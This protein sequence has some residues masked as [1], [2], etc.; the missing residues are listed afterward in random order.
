MVPMPN[1][2]SNNIR[3]HARVVI[4]A[5]ALL[6]AGLAIHPTAHLHAQSSPPAGSSQ[7]VTFGIVG[8]AQGQWARLNALLLPVGGPMRAGACEVTF[9][10]L[11]DQGATLSSSTLPV[12]QN[13]AVHFEYPAPPGVG[14]VPMEIRGTVGVAFNATASG[15]VA[16]GSCQALPTME[17]GN[18][19]GQTEIV[20][21]N[22]QGFLSIFPMV[23]TP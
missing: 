22:T 21:E 7:T 6:A 1:Y 23:V 11:N 2:I 17:I 14:T 12:N 8:L 10:F 5:L 18:W 20:L 3:N 15:A 19:S 9:T 16:G 4:L 13:Q